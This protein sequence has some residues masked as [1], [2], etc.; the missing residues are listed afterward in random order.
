MT[1]TTPS[2]GPTDPSQ[3]REV[4][5]FD[6]TDITYHRHVGTARA[7]GIVRIAF[8][9]PEVRNAFRPHT[10]DE[11]YTALDHA[12]RSPDVG[13]VLLTGNGPSPKDGGWAFCSGGDQRIRGRS[14]YR[15]ADGDTEDTVDEARTKAEGGRLH[16][17]EVQRLIRTMPKVVIAVVNGWAAGGGHSLHVVCDLTLASRE[18]AR[19]KQTDADVGSFDAGY[20]SAYLASQVGQKFAREIF[21]LGRTYDA[22]TMHRMGAVNEVVDHADLEDTAVEWGR[23]I[24]S[25]SPTA[26]RMLK[27]AFNLPEDGLM[28]QQVFAGEATRLAYMTDEAVEGRNSFLEKRPPNWDNFPY[29]Y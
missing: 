11:L 7:D 28:G 24:N 27:F 26:Q 5:G 2:T 13:T 18:H 14:G 6:F 4:P 19:F 17:L 8:D 1:D 12:R 15:Y 16:I 21:F 22:E 3:W 10:V 29:Y 20:G 9:R 25:K 23:A